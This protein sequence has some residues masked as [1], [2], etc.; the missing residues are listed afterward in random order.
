MS[1]RPPTL[2]ENHRYL[3]VR[4]E[5]AGISADQ[6]DL[7]Y[8]LSDAITS[9]WG[10]AMAAVIMQAVVATEGRYA[11]IRCRRGTERELAIALATVTVCHDVRIALR[12]VAASGTIDSLRRR[13]KA[14][15]PVENSGEERREYI[16]AGKPYNSVYC[17][18]QK[19]DVI[20][21]GF[22]NTHRLFL[23]REDMEEL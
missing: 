2:R 1:T 20:E 7:Y 4:I 11:V 17:D 15:K 16:I 23:T 18:V 19:I 14:E 21:K 8:A 22:K 10:D 6:K 3:L 13:I 9:L 5:P 12:I